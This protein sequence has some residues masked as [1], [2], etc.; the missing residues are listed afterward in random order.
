MARKYTADFFIKKFSR[1]P[2]RRWTTETFLKEGRCCALGHCGVD[3][4]Y[5]F[6]P[7]AQ[8]LIELMSVLPG[9]RAR[10]EQ[11]RVTNIND[12]V[13]NYAWIKGKTPR[14]RILNALREVKRLQKEQQA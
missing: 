8:A 10:D 1:I 3:V 12:H 4:S 2:R 13:T 14:T 6:T 5:Q 11:T 9:A 7:Q